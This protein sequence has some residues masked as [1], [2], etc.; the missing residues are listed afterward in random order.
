MSSER[1]PVELVCSSQISKVIVHAQGARIV[2]EVNLPESLE[3]GPLT[4]KV[5]GLPLLADPQSMRASLGGTSRQLV[6]LRPRLIIPEH[7]H[8]ASSAVSALESLED[9]RAR[10]EAERQS[11]SQRR[12]RVL[13]QQLSPSHHKSWREEGAD[14]RLGDALAI[15]DILDD[16]LL[17]IDERLL[18]LEQQVDELHR[19]LARQHLDAAQLPASQLKQAQSPS[20]SAQLHLRGDGHLARLELQYVVHA[21]CWWPLY[22]LHLEQGGARA[23]HVIEALIAQDSGE[24]W[25]N[26]PISLSTASLQYDATLPELPAMKL[27]RAQ[28]ARPSGYRP[29]PQGLDRLFHSYDEATRGLG[30]SSPKPAPDP[31]DRLI[32]ELEAS[33][34]S[35]RQQQVMKQ[36][37]Q[38][39]SYAFQESSLD[40]D[41]EDGSGYHE[42]TGSI[43][44]DE[45]AREAPAMRKSR[46]ILPSMPSMPS[47]GGGPPGGAPAPMAAPAPMQAAAAKPAP[48]MKK[49]MAS[50]GGLREEGAIG[51]FG[52]APYEPEPSSAEIA[53][54]DQWLD[55]DALI[56]GGPDAGAMRGKLK[57]KPRTSQARRELSDARLA[58]AKLHVVDPTISRGHYDYRYDATARV[59]IPS[60]AKTHR[61]EI[62]S[63]AGPSELW[64]RTIPQQEEAVYRM[65]RVQNPHALPLLKGP[66]DIFV[67]GSFLLSTVL[68]NIDKGGDM[69]VGLGVDER[70]RVARNARMEEAK[71]GFLIQNKTSLLHNVSIEL[72]S[73]LG[74]E[75]KVELLDRVPV[76]DDKD[77]DIELNSSDPAHKDYDQAEEGAAVRGGMRWWLT[78]EPGAKRQVEFNYTITISSKEELVGGNRR[79]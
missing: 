37:A 55:F 74:F 4:I 64:W 11:L 32:A 5:E 69:V 23:R 50:R 73:S 28:P 57:L 34:K 22:T 10:V 79:E 24:D 33:Q 9:E 6:A 58:A 47:F 38:L 52:D 51:G 3:P 40:V 56:L 21:A 45:I 44:F 1:G 15:S 8:A 61:V 43:M 70:V 25:V 39:A 16:R 46:S 7:G 18:V 75:A 68:E 49:E 59:E 60:D 35:Q 48:K 2:R 76:T 71:E 13:D 63:S 54:Q 29:P 53:P 20:W 12:K 17:E 31:V 42:V 65:A 19:E 77:I 72:S 62:M 67:E 14:A 66:V 41:E 30:F 27:G 36:E 78:L 26:V